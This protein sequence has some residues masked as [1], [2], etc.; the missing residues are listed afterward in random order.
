MGLMPNACV[1]GE[2]IASCWD[3]QL[4]NANIV[5]NGA[6]YHFALAPQQHRQFGVGNLDWTQTL[7]VDISQSANVYKIRL[8]L[9][10]IMSY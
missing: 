4:Y 7:D 6:K 9:N 10:E 5:Y 2:Y 8:E 3:T 1:H